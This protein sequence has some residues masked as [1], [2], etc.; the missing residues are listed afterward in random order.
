MADKKS[1]RVTPESV[2]L[3]PRETDPL[4]MLSEFSSTD[5]SDVILMP[6]KLLYNKRAAFQEFNVF[7]DSTSLYRD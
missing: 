7:L 5:D 1:T 4:K 3:K 6:R 2:G